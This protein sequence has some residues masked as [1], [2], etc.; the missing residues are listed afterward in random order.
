[1]PS[2]W[3]FFLHIFVHSFYRTFE[4]MTFLV[5]DCR[6]LQK[7]ECSAFFLRLAR[8][9]SFIMPIKPVWHWMVQPQNL[10]Y[11]VTVLLL[12]RMDIIDIL[13]IH[14]KSPR[15][16]RGDLRSNRG[17]WF[18]SPE[19]FLRFR[20][21]WLPYLDRLSAASHEAVVLPQPHHWQLPQH[22]WQLPHGHHFSTCPTKA[23]K[24]Q[25]AVPKVL[26]R[27]PGGWKWWKSSHRFLIHAFL[28]KALFG[29]EGSKMR[30]LQLLFWIDPILTYFWND[31]HFLGAHA[32]WQ[33]CTLQIL[34]YNQDMLWITQS[35][36][37]WITLN[38]YVILVGLD[39]SNW[40]LFLPGCFA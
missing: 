12:L 27:C 15:F 39:A 2:H 21:A 11:I 38:V 32:E 33:D 3:C 20:A 34:F 13:G 40:L 28:K 24:E 30:F 18:L 4:T 36:D 10:V 14:W 19:D 35:A 31:R 23:E 9:N 6:R 16:S 37:W 29:L 5:E 1:M 26:P 7:I 8:W 22:H 17:S 25:V